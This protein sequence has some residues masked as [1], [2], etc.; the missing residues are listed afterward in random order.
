MPLLWKN[1][2]SIFIEQVNS[3]YSIKTY[4]VFFLNSCKNDSDIV[5]NIHFRNASG[6]Y[7]IKTNL[8][9]CPDGNSLACYFKTFYHNIGI[10]YL[11]NRS[12]EII[13]ALW[14]L[15]LFPIATDQTQHT[16]RCQN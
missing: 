2:F 15:R 10:L 11:K 9:L 5:S 3:K 16:N 13:L 7:N 8:S 14:L 6:S 12:I 4:R 1:N